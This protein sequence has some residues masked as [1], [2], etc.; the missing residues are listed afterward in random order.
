MDYT[1]QREDLIWNVDSDGDEY[2]KAPSPNMRT[3]AAP[4]SSRNG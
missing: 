3:Q 4:T 2:T 1:Q